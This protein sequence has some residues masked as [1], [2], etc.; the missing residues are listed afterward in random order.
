MMAFRGY[1]F[2]MKRS[3]AL[4]IVAGL[5]TVSAVAGADISPFGVDADLQFR[6]AYHSRM[7]VVEDRPVAVVDVRMHADVGPFGRVGVL[8]WNYSSLCN[9]RSHIHRR[10]FNEVDFAAFWH[11]DLEFSE[12]FALSNEFMSWWITLPQ[13]VEP[14]RGDSDNSSYELWYVASFKNPYV[15]PSVLIRRGWINASWVYFQ[16]GLSKPF[17]VYDFGDVEAPR[18]LEVTPGFFVETGSNELLESRFGKKESGN[19]H[20]GV[21]SCIAQ[22]SMRWKATE[23]LSFH[24]MLQQFG[25]VSSDARDGV[26]GNYRRDFTMFRFGMN[27]VF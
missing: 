6:S 24:A 27:L 5:V 13:N 12:G 26:H 2:K 14:Y 15:V 21:A 22:I 3:I 8:H 23:N 9:R 17:E 18:P 11:Y 1:T 10:A 7:R 16:Y 20:T 25:V 4:A 19:Y